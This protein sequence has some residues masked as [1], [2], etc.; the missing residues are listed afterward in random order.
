ME[1]STFWAAGFILL[2]LFLFSF[3]VLD[4]FIGRELKI[5][6]LQQF[7]TYTYLSL[8]NPSSNAYSDVEADVVWLNGINVLHEQKVT[9]D[10]FYAGRSRVIKLPSISNATRIKATLKSEGEILE[11]YEL[12]IHKLN[13]QEVKNV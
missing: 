7:E 1:D 10:F 2:F 12:K 5:G 9:I 6:D 11:E 3:G 8:Q 4:P 13:V